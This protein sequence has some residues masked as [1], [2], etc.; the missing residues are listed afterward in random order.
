MT[1]ITAEEILEKAKDTT[2]RNIGTFLSK[3]FEV[4]SKDVLY[5]QLHVNFDL[6]KSP[7][8]LSLIEAR[9]LAGLLSK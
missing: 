2:S 6:S 4:K 7:H 9:K 3:E 1:R 5:I 8:K